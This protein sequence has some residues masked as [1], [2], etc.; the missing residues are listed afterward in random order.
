MVLL[1]IVQLALGA[2]QSIAMHIEETP[3]RIAVQVEFAAASDW[4]ADSQLQSLRATMSLLFGSEGRLA[5]FDVGA[6]V[7]VS[8]SWPAIAAMPEAAFQLQTV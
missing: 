6:K 3:G 1:P 7:A 8:V 5:I 4:D 2:A